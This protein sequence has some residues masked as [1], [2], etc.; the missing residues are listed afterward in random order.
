MI[1]SGA[2]GITAI[3]TCLEEGLEPVCYERTNRIGGLWYYT[4]EVCDDNDNDDTHYT[5]LHCLHCLEFTINR[6]LSR[7]TFHCGGAANRWEYSS[8]SACF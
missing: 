1:G 4:E 7:L 3:K 8:M 6:H 2:S 5:G